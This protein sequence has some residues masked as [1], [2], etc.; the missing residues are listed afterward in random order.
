MSARTRPPRSPVPGFNT[1]P[2]VAKIFAAGSVETREAFGG[3]DEAWQQLRADSPVGFQVESIPNGSLEGAFLVV[4]SGESA[5]K[6]LP[7]G[8]VAGRTVFIAV[9]PLGGNNLEVLKGLKPGDQ[10]QLDNSDFLAAQYYH[11]HQVPGPDFHVWDQFRGPDGK[12]T[13]PQ[14]PRLLGPMVTGTGTVQSGRF[15][16]KMIVCE[17]LMDQDAFP[18]QAD[19]YRAK[20]KAALG[21]HL[22]DNFRLWYTEH[23]VHSDN[24]RGEDSTH[25]VSY[26]GVLHQAL[27]D[28]S[29]WVEKGVPPPPSSTYEVIDGQVRV[30]AT[31]A[32]RNGIQPVVNLAANGH[33][34][35]D[36]A[37]GQRVRFSAVVE[38]PART[39]RIVSAE[40]DLQGDG[41]YTAVQGF[42]G[43]SGTRIALKATHAFSKP[44]T[45]FAALRATSQRQGDAKTLYARIH[46]LG[47]VRVVVR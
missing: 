9:N 46:N 38:V 11:R 34:R 3:V 1:K 39:G 19:W 20:V 27:R 16:G 25:T 40:W 47:R 21:E 44:G 10:V 5:G 14:R 15:Q 23:A 32:E 30:S 12:P 43:S 22:D 36:V 42:K 13:Y 28:V 31:A 17:S 24:Q 6:D 41:A 18:W 2:L 4:K 29:A 26:I 35:A 45:Y 8:R 7:I 33:A 37:V